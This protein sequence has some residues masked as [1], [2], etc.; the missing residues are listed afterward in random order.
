MDT[1]RIESLSFEYA[2]KHKVISNLNMTFKSGEVYLLDGPS[3]V[4][5]STLASLLAGHLSPLEGAIYLK[6]EKLNKPSRKVIVVHQEN[7]LFQWLT[8]RGHLDFLKLQELGLNIDKN[9]DFHDE[10]TLFKLLAASGQYPSQISGGMK[11]RLA[12]LRAM[13]LKP[14]VLILDESMSSLDNK[15]KIEIMSEVRALAQKNA[16]LLILID[17]NAQELMEF[18]DQKIVLKLAGVR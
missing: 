10:L 1:L 5:K 2:K 8:V 4:G 17:H 18:V 6:G 11:R 3:G 7:D 14:E 15:L 12:I 9:Y 16:T 13:M